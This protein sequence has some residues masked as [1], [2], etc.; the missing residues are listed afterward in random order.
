M[1]IVKSGKLVGAD[2]YGNKYFEDL[3]YF[4]GRSRWVEYASY[5]NLEFDASQV[6]PEW[7]G[8]LHYR[9][10]YPP[11]CDIAKIRVLKYKWMLDHSENLTGTPDAYMPYSTT[12]PKLEAWNPK[13]TTTQWTCARHCFPFAIK[14]NLSLID[15]LMI[16]L[17]L[18]G[19]PTFLQFISSTFVQ[20]EAGERIF[21]L[22]A[23]IQSVCGWGG[24]RKKAPSGINQIVRCLFFLASNRTQ[25]IELVSSNKCAFVLTS[26]LHKK[27]WQLFQLDSRFS[28]SDDDDENIYRNWVEG[29]SISLSLR[30][31]NVSIAI[32]KF[33]LMQFQAKELTEPV[34]T[35]NLQLHERR[36]WIYGD[37]YAEISF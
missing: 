19:L 22:Y 21:R 28:S 35:N 23:K 9:N 20:R 33:V 1:E 29:N 8:W 5:K 31:V 26:R 25:S 16:A 32:H 2:K 13:Q 10:D 34:Q 4:F 27:D 3:S 6:P 30:Q 36:K 7:F 12:K 37:R 14:K 17:F 24:R 11:N 18:P 15:H